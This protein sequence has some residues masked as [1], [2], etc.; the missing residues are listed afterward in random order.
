MNIEYKYCSPFLCSL[1]LFYFENLRTITVINNIMG[2]HLRNILNCE[3]TNL[4]KFWTHIEPN[5]WTKLQFNFRKCVKIYIFTSI[6][7]I[8][9]MC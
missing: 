5:I 3:N 4:V 7:D 9:L 8:H 1:K 6:S 2:F